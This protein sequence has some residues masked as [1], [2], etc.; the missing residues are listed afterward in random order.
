MGRKVDEEVVRGKDGSR[1]KS[2]ESLSYRVQ[3]AKLAPL[4]LNS[5]LDV[6]VNMARRY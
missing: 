5:M 1:G 3:A 2:R 4:L 6:E